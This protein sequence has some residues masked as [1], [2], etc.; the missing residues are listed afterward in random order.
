MSEKPIRIKGCLRKVDEEK[1][2][3]VEVATD[4]DLEKVAR[5]LDTFI[6][7]CEQR[8]YDL[9]IDPRSRLIFRK[10]RGGSRSGEAGAYS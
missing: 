2:S 9:V 10:R 3:V 4:E 5:A 8:G 7:E 1:F 6:L